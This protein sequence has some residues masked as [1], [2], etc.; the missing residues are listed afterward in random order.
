MGRR[1]IGCCPKNGASA[2]PPYRSRVPQPPPLVAPEFPKKAL[3]EILENRQVAPV[4][5]LL[6]V[7]SP[8]VAP[9]I[10]PGQFV[11]IRCSDSIVP[12][13]RR[14]MS[15]HRLIRHGDSTTGFGVLYDVVGPGTRALAMLGKGKRLDFVGPLGN[16]I[17]L[18]PGATRAVLVAGG[19]GVGPIKIVAEDLQRRG[20]RDITVCYGARNYDH[21]V[22]NEDV[23]PHGC[24]LLQCTDDGSVGRRGFVTSLVAELLAGGRLTPSTYV[25][26][27]GP[28]AMFRALQAL[29]GPA[30]IACEAAT[31]EFMGCGFGV[32]F[33]CS[34]RYRED[35]GRVTY[36]LCCVDGCMF[37]LDRLVYA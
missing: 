7:H 22:P 19:I 18:P 31:E 5:W 21:V 32:C 23:A 2:R 26:A 35:D 37:P 34:L 1:R 10:R 33:G 11:N 20:M 6:K 28:V 14:P 25:F 12:L 30:G 27:C 24:R 3:G 8:E 4:T 16:A 17:T 29:L 36:K 9:A 13:L 15:V